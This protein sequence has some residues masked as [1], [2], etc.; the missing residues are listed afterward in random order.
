MPV[1]VLGARDTMLSSKSNFH[2]TYILVGNAIKEKK[3]NNLQR[4]INSMKKIKQYFDHN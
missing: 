1:R 4:V 3:D 2:G